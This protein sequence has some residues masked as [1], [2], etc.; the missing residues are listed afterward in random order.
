MDHNGLVWFAQTSTGNIAKFDP[1]T[2]M[3]TEYDNP[4]WKEAEKIAIEVALENNV[5]PMKLR[6]MMWGM[7]YFPD[8]T[9]WYTDEAI[10]SIW[11]FSLSDESY[12]RI[13]YPMSEEA[14]SSLPQKL[15]IDGSKII[16]NDFTGGKLSFLDYAQDKQGLRHY[17]IPSIIEGA[18]AVSYTHLT[19]P[20]ILRV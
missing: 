12:V 6:S 8:G 5:E 3:F 10:D 16:I 1:L 13:S 19:L 14:E 17:A 11:K 18:V 7:D 9:I 4:I 2:E 20:T 15:V